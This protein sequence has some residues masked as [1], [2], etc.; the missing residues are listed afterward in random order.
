MS[1][2][3]IIGS[4]IGLLI[5]VVAIAYAQYLRARRPDKLRGPWA[6]LAALT[7]SPKHAALYIVG[8][9]TGWLVGLAVVER[10]G[11]GTLPREDQASLLLLLLTLAVLAL[12]IFVVWTRA[13]ERS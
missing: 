4:G 7:R 11:L 10:L 5:G 9:A 2:A 1:N 3:F 12:G 6:R 8:S 13:P